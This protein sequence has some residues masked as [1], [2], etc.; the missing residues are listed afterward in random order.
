MERTVRYLVAVTALWALWLALVGTT[1][2]Q[3]VVAGGIA[4][5]VTALVAGGA[6][7]TGRSLRILE[8]RRFAYAVAY[9]P[10]MAWAIVKANLDVARRVIDPRLPIRPGIV[11][12]K[13]RLK[14]PVARTA[15]ANSITLT[16]GTLSVD[17]CGDELCIHWVDVQAKDIEEATRE[18]VAGFERYL[19]VIFEDAA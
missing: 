17:I 2:P 14:H 13:T 9:V 11:R 15:L 5:V 19:E 18:I 4:A 6:P 10:Y 3:E 7:F 16:P 1:D 12:V 8:P